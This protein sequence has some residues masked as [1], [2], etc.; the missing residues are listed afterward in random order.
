MAPWVCSIRPENFE[1]EVLFE[2]KVVLLVCAADDDS[3][4]KQLKV[5]ENVAARYEKIL[6]VGLLAQD[7]L[8]IFKKRLKIIGTPTFL[9]M[10]EGKEVSRILGVS[11][12]L[13][14]TNLIDQHLSI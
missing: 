6:K 14:L 12:E 1:E 3:F 4:S 13:T 11:D 8:E 9:L 2:K 7:S 5:L 10:M